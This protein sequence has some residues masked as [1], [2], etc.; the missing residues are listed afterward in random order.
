MA[1]QDLVPAA[2]LGDDGDACAG[3][4]APLASDQ[5]YC[6]SCG[7]RRGGER[8]AYAEL[9][10]GREARTVLTVGD[11]EPEPPR[12][13][14]RPGPG[15]VGAF[16]AFAAVVLV[17]LG[18]VIG[19]LVQDEEPPQQLAAAPVRQPAP[20]VNVTTGGGEESTETSGAA[21][22]SDWPEG[23]SGFTVQLETLPIADSDQAAVDAAKSDAEGKGAKD[24]GALSSDE[25]TTL[26]P[27]NYV[28][29]SGVFAG[30]GAR[31]KAKA[32]LRKLRGD[33][34][35]AKVV[36]VSNGDQEF[37][38]E[39]DL[40]E[41]EVQEVDRGAL[42]DLENSTG[43]EQQKKSARLPDTL[44]IPGKPPPTDDRAPGGGQGG[45]TVIE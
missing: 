9:L 33:F 1:D 7:R 23:E 5:R 14:R 11:P 40:P 29:Y 18:V 43:E 22:T 24:V 10:S 34:R 20:I 2:P 39:E 13:P 45:G 42:E 3:C 12:E 19:V 35:D 37:A 41:E 25:Y 4:G 26:E 27:G 17:G 6:L 31:A 28:V 8:V 36:E 30:E 44:Q 32:A 15:L 38:V 16:A 21:F